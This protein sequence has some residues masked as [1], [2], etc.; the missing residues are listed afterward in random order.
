MCL[1]VRALMHTHVHMYTCVPLC[2]AMCTCVCVGRTRAGTCEHACTH[3]HPRVHAQHVPACTFMCTYAPRVCT[4]VCTHVDMC[5]LVCACVGACAY[6]VCAGMCLC[7]CALCMRR[8]R[9]WVCSPRPESPHG[10]TLPHSLGLLQLR[11]EA[12]TSEIRVLS[13]GNCVIRRHW[14]LWQRPTPN[15]TGCG[16]PLLGLPRLPAGQRCLFQRGGASG[17]LPAQGPL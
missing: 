8:A 9:L 7:V 3:T 6:V 10:S 2:A 14:E 5:L 12:A 16:R 1:C 15:H 13:T 17:E 11:Q 4:R